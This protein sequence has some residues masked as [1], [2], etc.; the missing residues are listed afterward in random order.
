L[1]ENIEIRQY[2]VMN[3]DRN[4]NFSALRS[5]KAERIFQNRRRRFSVLMPLMW[6]HGEWRL[7]FEVRSGRIRQG[8]EI[9]FPGGEVEEGESREEAAVRETA[10]ELLLPRDQIELICPMIQMTGPGGSEVDS[11]L[12]ILHDYRETFSSDE[13][14]RVFS[15]PL[16]YF[17][18]NP[19]REYRAELVPQFPEDFPFDEI[20]GGRDYPFYHAPRTYY[21]Y[22]TPYGALWGMTAQ[23]VHDALSIILNGMNQ[24]DSDDAKDRNAGGRENASV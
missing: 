5:H 17:A 23:L 19:P 6:E 3:Q 4:G 15:L 11:Y 12:G 2:N 16:S 20:P 14:A 1:L 10:E 24:M 7:L 13:V 9:C 18:E 22:R 8:G 21:F